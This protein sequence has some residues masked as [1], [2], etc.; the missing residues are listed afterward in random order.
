MQISANA[1]TEAVM[2]KT[3][4]NTD[5]AD[6]TCPLYFSWDAFFEHVLF[7]AIYLLVFRLF[8]TFLFAFLLVQQ[9]HVEKIWGWLPIVAFNSD[10]ETFTKMNSYAIIAT[11]VAVLGFFIFQVFAR[12]QSQRK[13]KVYAWY[14]GVLMLL[15]Q[16][17]VLLL[18][19]S[20]LRFSI[21]TNLWWFFVGFIALATWVLY[22]WFKYIRQWKFEKYVKKSEKQKSVK[23]KVSNKK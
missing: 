15:I 17:I 21:N 8:F 16:Y 5:N 11:G 6:K 14:I 20:R 3:N 1:M 2:Q 18:I 19:N 7:V 13:Y 4:I 12:Y 9:W 10:I 23:P 22:L